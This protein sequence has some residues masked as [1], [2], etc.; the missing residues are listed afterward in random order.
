MNKKQKKKKKKKKK[1]EKKTKK[2]KENLD[3]TD[4]IADTIKTSVQEIISIFQDEID[5]LDVPEPGKIALKGLSTLIAFILGKKYS[6]VNKIKNVLKI[7][8]KVAAE[9][10]QG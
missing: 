6:K 4:S 5:I 1:T 9:T 7:A 8:T 3:S 2:E 10:W